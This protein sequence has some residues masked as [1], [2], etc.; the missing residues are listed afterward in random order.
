MGAKVRHD[1]TTGEITEQEIPDRT[2]TT[3]WDRVRLERAPLLVEADINIFKAEDAGADTGTWRT[4]RQAL[5]NIT[6]QADPAAVTW[7]EKP[8][9]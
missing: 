9:D 5:R 1:L 8:E 3:T 2:P 7:P 4:Y 6:L